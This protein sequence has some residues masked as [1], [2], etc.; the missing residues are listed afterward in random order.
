MTD[1]KEIIHALT[2]EQ[3]AFLEE[4][5]KKLSEKELFDRVG[6]LG[7]KPDEKSFSD[8]IHEISSKLEEEV[9]SRNLSEEELAATSGGLCGLNGSD[10]CGEL[11]QYEVSHCTR[12]VVREIYEGAFPNCA[13]TVEDGSWCSSNDACYSQQ[14]EYKGMKE[15]AKAW[16]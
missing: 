13:A 14:V 2:E 12:I 10:G 7:W 9:F 3:K 1:K 11:I 5:F 15:C 16:K 8:V 6:E 4:N